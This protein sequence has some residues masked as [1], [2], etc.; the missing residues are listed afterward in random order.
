MKHIVTEVAISALFDKIENNFRKP[1]IEKLLDAGI[2]FIPHM[3]SLTNDIS[4]F[5]RKKELIRKDD[6]ETLSRYDKMINGLEDAQN[7][8]YKTI[9]FKELAETNLQKARQELSRRVD[10][11]QLKTR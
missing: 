8:Y 2:I 6:T 5:K 7:I 11:N 9:T 3:K 4:Y 1:E 10:Y